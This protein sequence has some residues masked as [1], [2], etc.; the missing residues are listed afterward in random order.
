MA[1]TLRL[2]M[3]LAT[4]WAAACST[5]T[6]G[7]STPSNPCKPGTYKA[8]VCGEVAG[9]ALCTFTGRWADCDCSGDVTIDPDL[10]VEE[11][12]GEGPGPG[13]GAPGAPS[14]VVEAAGVGTLT[15]ENY[16]LQILVAPARP[17]AE[18]QSESYRLRLRVEP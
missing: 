14:T 1:R 9:Y 16:K 11:D 6:E 7:T 17:I 12:A 18:A 8:C 15:S 10:L 2:A 5:D 3:V 13:P 4:L